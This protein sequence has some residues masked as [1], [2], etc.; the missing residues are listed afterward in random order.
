MFEISFRAVKHYFRTSIF[1]PMKIPIRPY[2]S[3][4]LS[5][6]YIVDRSMPECMSAVVSVFPLSSLS[7]SNIFYRLCAHIL[8]GCAASSIISYSQHGGGASFS[9]IL[10][11]TSTIRSVCS[12]SVDHFVTDRNCFPSGDFTAEWCIFI[13]SFIS[14]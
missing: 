14:F 10:Q 13:H 3:A 11:R 12:N 8:V 7:A 2:M 4:P 9:E 1:A 6:L 5:W